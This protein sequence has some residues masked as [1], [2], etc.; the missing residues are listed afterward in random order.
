MSLRPDHVFQ[1][2]IAFERVLSLRHTLKGDRLP[3]F[4]PLF[5]GAHASPKE[6]Q[7]ID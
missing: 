1:E 3:F 6:R 7:R 5:M 2:V 4:Y